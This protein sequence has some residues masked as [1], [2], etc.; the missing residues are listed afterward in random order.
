MNPIKIPQENGRIR[1]RDQL[2]YPLLTTLLP[3][4]AYLVTL[5]RPDTFPRRLL[6]QIIVEATSRAS[7]RLRFRLRLFLCLS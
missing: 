7:F 5:F 4:T 2:L 1:D 6:A 3:H